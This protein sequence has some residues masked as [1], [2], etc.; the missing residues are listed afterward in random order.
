MAATVLVPDGP[1]CR[2]GKDRISV[3]DWSVRVFQNL[4][5]MARWSARLNA[6]VT[7]V[8]LGS[9]CG[10]V[11]GDAIVWGVVEYSTWWVDT[12]EAVSAAAGL[13]LG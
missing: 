8:G 6:M 1:M 3:A 9:V 11:T 4:G 5:V 13:G 10:L 2:G 7:W 12:D